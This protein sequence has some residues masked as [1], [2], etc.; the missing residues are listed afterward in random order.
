MIPGFSGGRIRSA[1]L[2]WATLWLGDL[3]ALLRVGS[4]LIA[5]AL[6]GNVTG[7]AVANALFGLSGLVGLGLAACLLVNL[8]PALLEPLTRARASS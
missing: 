3:A 2:V 1:R 5:P 7:S 8:W 6:A 4:L